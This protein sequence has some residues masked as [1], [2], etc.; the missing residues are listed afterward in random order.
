MTARFGIAMLGGAILLVPI[1]V[2][3]LVTEFK[4]Q[5][6]ITVL[7]VLFFS[8]LL[9][10]S[11]VGSNPTNQELLGATAVYAAVLI[12]FLAGNVPYGPS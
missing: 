3:S 6:L 9:P 10:L 7:F 11:S 12:V 5:L 4:F 2:L 8:W 1:V